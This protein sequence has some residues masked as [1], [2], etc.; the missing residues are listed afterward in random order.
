MPSFEAT[1]RQRGQP[2]RPR[3]WMAKAPERVARRAR[4]AP[5][6][7]A[8]SSEGA[9]TRSIPTPTAPMAPSR[10]SSST[11]PRAGALG[12]GDAAGCT[13]GDGSG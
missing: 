12:E 3:A 5:T 10:S 7:V 11:K 13:R 6:A 9:R 8:A 2:V 4:C 1:S